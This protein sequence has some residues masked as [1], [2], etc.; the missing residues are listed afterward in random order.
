MRFVLAL[1][2]AFGGGVASFVSPCVLPLVPVYLSLVTGFNADAPAASVATSARTDAVIAPSP[3]SMLRHSALFVAGFSAVFVLLGSTASVVGR[4]VDAN[5][6]L[7]TR[8]AGGLIIAMAAFLALSQRVGLVRLQRSWHP[9]IHPSRAGAFAAPL[10][11]VAFGFAWTPC[12]GPVLASILAV[13][14]T[15]G[16][17]SRGAGLLAAYSLGLGL[18]FLL[19][20][21]VIGRIRRWVAWMRGHLRSVTL[22][23][24]AVLLGLGVLVVTGQLT[25]LDVVAMGAFR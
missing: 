6:L 14:S 9:R 19:G 12:I 23:S 17:V 1:F 21:L 20:S 13:A 22:V 18:P 4:S 16:D 8:V 7:L 15:Q 11:G 10:I 3:F 5:H 25:A 24:S 2:L